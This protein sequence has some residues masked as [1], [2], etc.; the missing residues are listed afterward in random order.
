MDLSGKVVVVPVAWEGAP[1]LA[2]RLGSAGATVV[3]V[4][5]DGQAAGRLAAMLEGAGL[6]GRPAVFV[7]DGSP[8]SMDELAA[9]VAEL[10]RGS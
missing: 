3:L 10:F 2:A 6:P 9:F 5:D 8:Q 7:S 1:G 4:G